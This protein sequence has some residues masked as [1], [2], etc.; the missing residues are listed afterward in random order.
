MD[1]PSVRCSLR[2]LV[3]VPSFYPTVGGVETATL[4]LV[5]QLTTMGEQVV[6][7]T[8]RDNHEPSS[9]AIGR[10][11]YRIECNPSVATLLKWTCWCEITVHANV[12]MRTLWPMYLIWRP[13]VIIHHHRLRQLDHSSKATLVHGSDLLDKKQKQRLTLNDRVKRYFAS[14]ADMNIAVSVSLAEDLPFPTLVLPNCYDQLTYRER[15]VPDSA[16]VRK[17][18]IFV[19]RLVS[20]KGHWLLFEALVSLK[21]RGIRLVG[22]FVGDGP[23]RSALQEKLEASI[24]QEDVRWHPACS[25]SALE[26]LFSEHRICVVPSVVP[27]TFGLVALEAMACGCVIVTSDEGA[28]PLVAGSA[29]MQFKSGSARSLALAL[30][31]LYKDVSQL[32]ILL[33]A[34]RIRVASFSPSKIA[35][36]YAGAFRAVTDVADLSLQRSTYP[37]RLRILVVSPFFPNIGGIETV[38][39]LLVREWQSAGHEVKVIHPVTVHYHSDFTQTPE[40]PVYYAP[41]FITTGLLHR[42]CDIVVHGSLNTRYLPA[43][44]LSGKPCLITQHGSITHTGI[45]P[46]SVIQK[47]KRWISR[48]YPNFTCSEF[49]ARDL[50]V[51]PLGTGNPYQDDVFF[52]D[53]SVERSKDLIFVGRI[54]SDKGLPL[55]LRAL[56]ELRGQKI[57]VK[58]TVIGTGPEL[59]LCQNL[60]KDLGIQH[61]VTFLGVL[62]PIEVAFE[63]RQH[64]ILVVPSLFWEPFGI[65]ALEGI[66]CGCMVIGSNGGGMGESVGP[67]GRLFE[68]NSLEGLVEALKEVWSG[69]PVADLVR[70]RHLARFRAPTIASLVLKQIREIIGHSDFSV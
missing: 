70:E 61:A 68:N 25:G 48:R 64:R 24:I 52:D 16:G 13:W 43:L 29:G 35:I 63:L 7:V 28:A 38:F 37:D 21:K 45:A 15:L 56:Y 14:R 20:E 6:V 18:V 44:V 58:L 47:M 12:N 34:A 9:V 8:K 67:C 27:E 33:R 26:A 50:G 49:V 4:N 11:G 22:T 46:L 23:M 30:E 69:T 51:S 66:A 41:S 5:E 19:G 57:C 31:R 2:I 36:K 40:T 42:W 10:G 54:V 39:T 55:L 32:E 65:V 62:P 53:K 60:V 59:T 1:T 3:H 17:D